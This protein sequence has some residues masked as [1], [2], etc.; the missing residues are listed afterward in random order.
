MSLHI[1][2]VENDWAAG[3]QLRVASLEVIDEVPTLT[4]SVDPKKWFRVLEID[5]LPRPV[6]YGKA[7]ALL[8]QVSKRFQGDY[9]FATEPHD[10]AECEYPKVGYLQ[11]PG[12][13][14]PTVKKAAGRH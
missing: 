6:P 12:Q 4:E 9:V 11:A 7:E 1:D 2:F 13:P 5:K 14:M 8:T 10:A 3:Q